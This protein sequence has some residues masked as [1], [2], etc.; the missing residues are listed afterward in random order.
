[1][2]YALLDDVS[3][4]CNGRAERRRASWGLAM[5]DSTR[6]RGLS[7]GLITVCL[8]V[9]ILAQPC[10][11]VAAGLGFLKNSALGHFDQEDVDL[12]MRNAG[13]VLESTLPHASQSWSNP[14][15]GNSG[16]AEVLSTF[17]GADGVPCK[18]VRVSN[19]V[20]SG[21]IEDQATYTVCKYPG[22]G[23]LLNGDVE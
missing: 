20:K 15:S 12:M 5:N 11:A 14:K 17:T 18:R 13:Q 4:A 19:K 16:A 22:R 10:S 21:N 6:R 9:L 7:G 2:G 1:M 8:A 23:W 3:L